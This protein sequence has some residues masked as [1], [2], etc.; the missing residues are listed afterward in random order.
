LK[1]FGERETL[2][3]HPPV[4]RVSIP[5]GKDLPIPWKKE[6]VMAGQVHLVL[7][8]ALLLNKPQRD[9][10]VKWIRQG[11]DP[12]VTAAGKSLNITLAGPLDESIPSRAKRKNPHLLRLQLEFEVEKKPDRA[13]GFVVGECG[14]G[15]ISITRHR[16]MGVCGVDQATHD[17]PFLITDELLGHALANT[18]LHELGH[19][20]ANFDDNRDQGNFMSTVGPPKEERTLTT[21]REFWAGVQTWTQDQKRKLV[22]NITAGRLAFDEEEFQVEERPEAP[23]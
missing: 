23:K 3:G 4:L 21:Q 11:F 5:F 18:A 12:L 7:F 13:C 6:T 8:G 9:T 17:K 22:E 16:F 19:R 10:L 20:I 2:R 1:A 15:I 14:S